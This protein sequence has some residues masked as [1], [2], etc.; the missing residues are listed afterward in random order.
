MARTLARLGL[1]R[2]R[3][4]FHDRVVVITGASAGVGRAVARRFSRA[5]ARVGLIARD[6]DALHETKAEI[7]SAGGV[8][9]PL[10]RLIIDGEIE[11]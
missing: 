11:P 10:A 7:E 4:D 9:A 1:S 2:A 3:I 6:A 8:P 5:G